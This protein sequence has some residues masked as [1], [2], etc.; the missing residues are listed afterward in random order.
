MPPRKLRVAIIGLGSMGWNHLRVYRRLE[1]VEL[2]AV[3]DVDPQ[4][5][6]RA[7]ENSDT[8]AYDDYRRL[9]EEERV[10]LVSVV[11]PTRLHKEVATA[12]IE[13]GAHVLVEKPIASTIDEG[14]EMAHKAEAASVNLMVGH[15]ERFNPAL[16]ELKE[17]L[18]AGEIGNILQVQAR[19]VGPF[20]PRVRDVG[21][22]HDLATH[23]IDIIRLLLERE[24][25]QIYART[26]R[27]LKTEYED[28]L[29]GI[30]SFDDDVIALLDVNWLSPTK[31]RQLTVFGEHGTF[32]AD[33]LTQ[34]L[35]L[36][37]AESAEIIEVRRRE[38]LEAELSAFA[39]AVR[40]G[41][42]APV[43]ANDGIAA[44]RI[45]ELLVESGRVG[46]PIHTLSS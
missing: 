23:D 29:L 38:P 17:R 3:A 22:V 35:H 15:I 25:T 33:Y 18:L 1:G 13:S 24:P 16:S 43:S 27:G 12:A 39:T 44:L 45:A 26:R 2:V 5:R 34:D 11:V 10:D 36:Q 14:V 20:Q 32:I 8:R 6:D 41:R 46:Q 7:S 21:V 4:L 19:R 37:R 28:T 30:L 31:V 42:E 9:F 40:D